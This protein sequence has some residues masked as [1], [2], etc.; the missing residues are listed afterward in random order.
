[1]RWL[2][3]SFSKLGIVLAEYKVQA[4]SVSNHDHLKNIQ[5]QIVWT[6]FFCFCRFNSY[7]WVHPM[8][9]PTPAKRVVKCFRWASRSGLQPFFDAISFVQSVV[10][11]EIWR[12]GQHDSGKLVLFSRCIQSSGPLTPQHFNYTTDIE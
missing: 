5:N 11:F 1:M 3:Q 6:L 12:L 7:T 9:M 8:P 10:A 2:Q 4:T